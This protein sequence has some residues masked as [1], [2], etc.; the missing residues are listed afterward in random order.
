MSREPMS[1]LCLPFQSFSLDSLRGVDSGSRSGQIL[2]DLVRSRDR[3]GQV[4]PDPDRL[5]KN[6]VLAPST[7]I[8]ACV[9]P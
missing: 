3:S 6:S 2:L 1:T 5:R 9:G 7:D 8:A 4:W